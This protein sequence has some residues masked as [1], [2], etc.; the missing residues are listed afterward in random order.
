[1]KVALKSPNT[2]E[3]IVRDFYLSLIKK[4]TM[5]AVDDLNSFV[6]EKGILAHM[7]MLREK[8]GGRLP[9]PPP[10]DAKKKSRPL[11]PIVITR[12]GNIYEW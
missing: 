9:P 10:E 1:M 2:D 8:N 5:T 12:Q 4:T 11:K 6:E 7:K 3:E